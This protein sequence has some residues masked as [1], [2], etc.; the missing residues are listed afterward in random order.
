MPKVLIVGEQG[1]SNARSVFLGFGLGF[2][3]QLLMQAL[4]LWKGEW[5]K[6]ITGITGYKNAVV[7]IDS[8]PAFLGVGYIIGPRIASVLG[9]RRHHDG[10]S[11]R[12]DDFLFRRGPAGRITTGT[13]KNQRDESGRD[14]ASMSV[15]S[16][17][18]RSPPAAS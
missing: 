9:R 15:I 12:A 13:T 1:G 14:P 7:A 5:E 6:T 17:P 4:K 8:S 16:A 10:T 3:F 2:I 18:A 11:A